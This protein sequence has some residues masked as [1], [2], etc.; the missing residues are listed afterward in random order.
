M[1]DYEITVAGADT[2]P[3]QDW[4]FH[5]VDRAHGVAQLRSGERTLSVVVEGGGADWVVTVHGR[6][7]PVTV[8]NW[9]ERMLA[10]A[11]REARLHAGPLTVK[12]TLPGLVVA[13]AVEAGSEVSEG[14]SLLTIEAMKM[15]NEIRAPRAG[16]VIEVSVESGQ[17]VGTGA[18]LL[19]LE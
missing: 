7:V 17:A 8:R 5:W 6:R 13:V 11:E 19:R 12:A 15:Q 9:R 3:A 18:P 1:S 10:D 4:S 16:R 14:D 2:D